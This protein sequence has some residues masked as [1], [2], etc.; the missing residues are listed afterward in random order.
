MEKHFPKEYFSKYALVTFRDDIPYYEAMKK[1]R[2]QDKA[3][4]NLIAD[5]KINTHL[6]MNQQELKNILDKIKAQ[7]NTIL[8]EDKIAGL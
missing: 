5:Q 8:Q 2:A 1:G 3:L 6:H 4:L 7:T